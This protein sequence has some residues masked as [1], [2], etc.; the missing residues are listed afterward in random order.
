MNKWPKHLPELTEQ[1][2][3]IREDFMTQ[4]HV[5]L[6]KKKKY[7]AIERFNH[8]VLIKN[9]Q[10]GGRVLEIGAGLGEH[11]EYEDLSK[12]TEYCAMEMR[13]E[14]AQVLQQRFPGVRVIVGDCQKRINS[15]DHS[16]DR[17]IAVHVL[18]HL[19]NL[20]EAIKEAYRLLKPTG[21]FCV[22]IPC[23]GGWAYS[24]ARRLSAQRLFKKLYGGMEYDW[25][26]KSEHINV[27]HEII[28]ELTPYF[29]IK[30]KIFFPFRVPIVP[31]N[32]VICLI[33]KPRAEIISCSAKE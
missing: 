27:P 17:I 16:F 30:K 21:E 5:E 25:F 11:I 6:A 24:L 13:P 28:E 12:L 22:V 31:L 14:M 32:L 29:Q 23:E 19:P 1:Q 26:V 9:S 18:E 3:S 7:E 15:P 2:K 4:W 10:S 8:A 20:P 33:L